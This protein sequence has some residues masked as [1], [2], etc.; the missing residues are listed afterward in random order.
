MVKGNGTR[1]G[2]LWEV[3]RLLGEMQE[4]PQVLL[5]ENVPQVLNSDFG[6][7]LDFLYSLGYKNYYKKLNAKNFGTTYEFNGKLILLLFAH[8]RAQSK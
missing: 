8:L 1:S 6:G 2:L 5:M 3:E 4:L 7:W